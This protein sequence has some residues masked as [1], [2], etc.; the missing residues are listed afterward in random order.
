MP[1]APARAGLVFESALAHRGPVSPATDSYDAL[2]RSIERALQTDLPE[3]PVAELAASIDH[4]LLEEARSGE[5]TLA[6]LRLL[7][8]GAYLAVALWAFVAPE[9]AAAWPYALLGLAWSGGAVALVVALRRGWYRLWLRH[10]VPAADA[11]I[12]WLTFLLLWT[13]GGDEWTRV[14]TAAVSYVTALCAFLAVSG[15]LRLSRSSAQLS[16]SLAVAIFVFAAAAA[17]L[18]VVHGIAIAVTLAVAGA[19]SA[20]APTRIRRVVT[21]QVA[22]MALSRM[23]DEARQAIDAREEVLKIV[24]HDLRNPLNTISMSAGL[25]LEVDV[26]QEQRIKQLAMIKRAG[27][28]MNRLIQDLLDVAKL[29]AGRLGIDPRPIDVAPLIGEALDMLRPIASEKSI[30]LD[31]VVADRLPTIS[32]DAGR[33]LQVLSNLVGNAVKFT[34]AGGRVTIRVE[35]VAGSVRFCVADTGPGIPPEQLPHIFGR[36]WQADRSDRRGIG[37]GLAIAKGI[38]EAH[39]GRISVESRVGEGTS[40]YFTLR[41]EDAETTSAIRERRRSDY[42]TAQMGG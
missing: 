7:A 32:A 26:P 37:L 23:Y 27:E 10:V 41:N 6:Y 36:F 20:T 16:T 15:A 2:R 14:S 42:P 24:S 40:F 21:H 5:L 11:A 3:G 12:I 28:R 34:P 35:A 8:V 22:R 17:D 30:R 31:V 9:R 39:G 33:V 4:A 1:G 19:L 29:E 13:R 18:N 25:M 38:V